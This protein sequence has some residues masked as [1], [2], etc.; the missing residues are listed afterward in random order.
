MHPTAR[1]LMEIPYPM[2]N[3]MDFFLKSEPVELEDKA[4]TDV[5]TYTLLVR[6]ADEDG[7]L[8]RVTDMSEGTVEPLRFEELYHP[9]PEA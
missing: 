9:W 8:K 5:I 7:F 4:F 1:Y 2:L 6:T 3:R